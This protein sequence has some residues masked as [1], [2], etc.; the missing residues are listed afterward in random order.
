MTKRYLHDLRALLSP[1]EH[2]MFKKLSSPKRIQDFLEALPQNFSSLG[3]SI[4]NPRQVL[5]TKKAHC[6]E[7]AIMAAAALAYHG[8]EPLLLDLQS[9]AYD[10]DHVVTLFKQNGRWGAISK[11]NHPV[12]RWRDPV[13][14][15]VRELAMSYFHEYFWPDAGKRLGRKTLRTYSRPFS[16]CR[17]D[18]KRWWA[19]GE[20]GRG[21][22]DWLAEELDG[23][24]H[25]PI[26]GPAQ[27]KYV[28]NATA[29]EI[30]AMRLMGWK[31]PRK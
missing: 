18:P 3:E 29:L 9:S 16:L 26:A 24:P 15:S 19:P 7:G 13:Y 17:Y 4:Q 14:K 27:F 6:I 5:R 31:K 11:T 23:S 2:Q 10:Q 21:D 22:L 1:A 8:K 30:K 20:G 25:Y 28:R 12:L